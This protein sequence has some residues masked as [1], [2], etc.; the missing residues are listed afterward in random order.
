MTAIGKKVDRVKTSD[1]LIY[2]SWTVVEYICFRFDHLFLA[3]LAGSAA[4]V[5]SQSSPKT[6]GYTQTPKARLKKDN[7]SIERNKIQHCEP[8]SKREDCLND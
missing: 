6:A 7:R 1:Y 5:T 8:R 2:I 4:V 3:I